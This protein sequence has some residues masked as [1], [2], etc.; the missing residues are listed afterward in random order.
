MTVL[1]RDSGVYPV[2]LL[3]VGRSLWYKILIK[4]R[5]MWFS[6]GSDISVDGQKKTFIHSVDSHSTVS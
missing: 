3:S 6:F 4:H 1:R 2:A 5:D